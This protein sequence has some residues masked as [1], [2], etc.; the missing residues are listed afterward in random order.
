MIGKRLRHLQRYQEIINAF[1]KNG[2]SYVVKE[3]GLL[4]MFSIRKKWSSV[5]QRNH[6]T[7]GERIRC[8]LEDLG[9]SFVKLG[10][11]ASIRPDL[12]PE[13]IIKELEKLQD[14]VPPFSF[15]EVKQ[16]LEEELGRNIEELFVEFDKN[17]LAAASIG[18]VHYAILPS[19]Q[20]VAVKIQRPNMKGIVET[21]LEIIADLARLAENKFEWA[22]RH[23]LSELV[24]E[25]SISMR[26]EL[27]YENEGRNAEKLAHHFSHDEQIVV[28][29]IYWEYTTKKVLTSD[30]ISGI[31]ISHVDKLNEQEQDCKEIAIRLAHA[32]LKQIL[33]DGFFHGDPHPGNIIVLPNGALG[34]LD[35]GVM[36]KID[37]DMKYHFTSLVIAMQRQSTDGVMKAISQMGLIPHDINMV[38]FRADVDDLREKYYRIPFSKIR[39][40]EVMKELFSISFKYK[41]HF[42]ADLSLLGKSLLTVEGIVERLNPNLNMVKIAEPF[43]KQLLKDRYSPKSISQR[44]WSSTSE[45]VQWFVRFPEYFQDMMQKG[46][47]RFE[48]TIP[49]LESILAKMDRIGRRV[50]NSI[51]LL[52]FSII[53]ASL[54]I[55]IA[56]LDKTAFI[57]TFPIIEIG[58]IATIFIVILLLYLIFRS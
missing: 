51:V 18:Q 17:P 41:I 8:F 26:K 45:F 48:V 21:D 53:I 32:F 22:A 13:D 5:K 39:F 46:K 52:S 31:K 7:R 9:P 1:I 10:Q 14:S 42:P 56:L 19:N 35:F 33:I 57:S 12:V 58:L 2:F 24:E 55:S 50:S 40:G 30:F 15:A 25:L 37:S 49:Q 11:M 27:D 28:P 23:K 38:A 4:E 34:L 3:L 54:V 43:G 44:I 20:P 16:I 6:R 36:G 47:F 29:N